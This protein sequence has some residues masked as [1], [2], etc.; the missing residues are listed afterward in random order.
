[1]NICLSSANVARWHVFVMRIEVYS[2]VGAGL[3]AARSPRQAVIESMVP[4]LDVRI[5]LTILSCIG[6]IL[7]AFALLYAVGTAV[8]LIWPHTLLKVA[9]S[10]ARTP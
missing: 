9:N 10:L 5:V 6:N 1:M 4:L 2:S 7:V 8:L 3:P